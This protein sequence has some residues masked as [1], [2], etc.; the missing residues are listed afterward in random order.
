MNVSFL[1]EPTAALPV[2]QTPLA[3]TAVFTA[4]DEGTVA[5]L[6]ETAENE[7]QKLAFQKENTYFPLR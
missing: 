1:P 7:E 2:A 6:L 5:A 3:A 4:S